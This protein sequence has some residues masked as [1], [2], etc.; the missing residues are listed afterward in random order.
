MDHYKITHWVSQT[1]ININPGVSEYKFAFPGCAE[2][3]H[4]L[5]SPLQSPKLSP[6]ADGSN[7]CCIIAFS[8]AGHSGE[9]NRGNQR[10]ARNCRQTS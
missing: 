7:H 4:A 2:R 3:N 6:P 8:P 1:L 10:N 5:V 9:E